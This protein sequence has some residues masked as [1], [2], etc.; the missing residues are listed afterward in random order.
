MGR[1]ARGAS[2]LAGA[3]AIAARPASSAVAESVTGTCTALRLAVREQCHA[4]IFGMG[5]IAAHTRANSQL[6]A[7]VVRLLDIQNR[8]NDITGC[9]PGREADDARVTPLKAEGGE[10]MTE[11]ATSLGLPTDPAKVTV[12][13]NEDA[14]Q[15]GARGLGWSRAGYSGSPAKVVVNIDALLGLGEDKSRVPTGLS[16]EEVVTCV[17]HDIVST[18][19]HEYTHLGQA[20]LTHGRRDIVPTDSAGVNA[21]AEFAHLGDMV[22][23]IALLDAD[24]SGD[25]TATD[26][27]AARLKRNV[28][29]DAEMLTSYVRQAMASDKMALE[30]I[31]TMRGLDSHSKTAEVSLSLHDSATELRESMVKRQLDGHLITGDPNLDRG[32]AAATRALVDALDPPAEWLAP[33]SSTL[34]TWRTTVGKVVTPAVPGATTPALGEPTSMALAVAAYGAYRTTCEQAREAVRNASTGLPPNP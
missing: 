18:L 22:Y 32:V 25:W 13:M 7:L 26:N 8:I 15:G 9:D 31:K 23:W 21:A 28:R 1:A 5:L 24:E 34:T 20:G 17:K 29:D 14:R 33:G 12:S 6:D 11:I 30:F 3:G 10:I 4:Q 16:P 27:V 19:C 2:L